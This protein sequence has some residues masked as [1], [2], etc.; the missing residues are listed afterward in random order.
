MVTESGVEP[1]LGRSTAVKLGII[2]I[3]PNV[4]N[5]IDASQIMTDYK[6][7]FEGT[8]KLEDYQ[9]KLHIYPS[10]KPVAQPARR[11]PLSLRDKLKDK[12]D[13]VIGMDII[14]PVEVPTSWVS[15][16][17]V[18]LKANEEIRLFVDVRRANE[19]IISERHPIATVDEV[20][21]SLNQ[22]TVFSK[23]D[24][25]WGYHQVELDPDSRNIT[26]FVT[27]CGLY[28]NKRLMFGINPAPKIYQHDSAKLTNCE[29]SANVPDDIIVHAK[30]AKPVEEHDRV[31]EDVIK[32]MKAKNL[33]LNREK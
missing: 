18:V 25:K 31:L 30:P 13:E 23:L 2:K 19:A 26:T 16:V 32:T 24:L 29:N 12:I 15:P 11:I 1:Q 6:E 5:V 27:Y 7:V 9:L 17:V 3:R 21:H 28:R 10:V 20:L 33:T 22:S 4:M 14:E 8:G